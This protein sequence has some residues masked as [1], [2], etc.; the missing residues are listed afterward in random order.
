[1]ESEIRQSTPER[2]V[3]WYLRLNGFLLLENFIIHPDEGSEQRTDADIL[4][5]RF[6][7]RSEN[8]LRPMQDDPQVSE[9]PTYVN[10][11]IGEVKRGYCALNGPWT[12]PVSANMQR[13]LRALGCFEIAELEIAAQALYRNGFYQTPAATCRLLAFG[14]QKGDLPIPNV[15]QILFSEMI[16]FIFERIRQ[17]ETKVSRGQ[18]GVGRT[19]PA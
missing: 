1:M 19:S 7:H 8:I 3:Y 5:V 4:G 6:Q 12:Q 14:N 2:L 15:P 17:Y 13:V 10:V 9:C 16:A 11:I 18:L